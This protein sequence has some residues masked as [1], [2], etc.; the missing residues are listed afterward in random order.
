M[1]EFWDRRFAAEGKIWGENPSRSA[2]HALEMF[3]R[4]G[5][6]EVLVPGSGYGRNSRLFAEAGF[7]VTGVEISEF[8]YQMARQDDPYS[9]FLLGSVLELPDGA[10]QFEGIYCFN[11]LHLF[12]R[13]GRQRLVQRWH[14]LLR[15][16]G[17][18][19]VTVFSEH[20]PTFGVGKRVEENTFESKIGRPV[21]YYSEEDLREELSAFELIHT[22]LIEEPEEHGEGTHVHTLRYGVARKT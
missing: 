18:L 4:E 17:V 6:C 7:Q 22:D 21:H 8:A 14:A 12:D 2:L 16:N 1:Q 15:H 19:F 5:L 11:V 3:R 13:A 9:C 10:A 20:E